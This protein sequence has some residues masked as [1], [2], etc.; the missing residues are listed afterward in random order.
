MSEDKKIT[1]NRKSHEQIRKEALQEAHDAVR[2]R[3][4]SMWDLAPVF[5]ESGDYEA[6][7]RFKANAT[8][9]FLAADIVKKI[10]EEEG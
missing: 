7:A 6:A 1:R 5:A 3:G 8:Q 4:D 10:I 2:E 9:Y